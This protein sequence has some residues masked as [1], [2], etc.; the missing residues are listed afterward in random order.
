M[1]CISEGILLVEA[2][3]DVRLDQ[4]GSK[5]QPPFPC[6][7][8][9]LFNIEGSDDVFGCPLLLIHVTHQ[10]CSGLIFALR[11]NHTMADAPGL[12]HFMEAVAQM[13]GR[14]KH[15]TIKPLSKR[16]LLIKCK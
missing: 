5:L 2:D 1:E 4:F 8:D 7:N 13:A 14:F 11:L 3:A 9:M 16:E 12:V 15:P 6:L 10:F